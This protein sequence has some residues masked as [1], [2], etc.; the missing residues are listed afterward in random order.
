MIFSKNER[1]I[2]VQCNNHKL[3][4]DFSNNG[5]KI[6]VQFYTSSRY[7]CIIPKITL[8]N[9][10]IHRRN[11]IQMKKVRTVHRLSQSWSARLRSSQFCV[12][13][14]EKNFCACI[15]NGRRFSSTNRRI[16][17]FFFRTI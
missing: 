2:P 7:Y 12:T 16:S 17:C 6:P 1:K 13:L 4:H 15:Q 5:R 10:T 14:A 3:E 9:T 8:R 11:C